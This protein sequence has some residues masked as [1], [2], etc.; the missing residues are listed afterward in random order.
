M[1]ESIAELAG[2]RD[3]FAWVRTAEGRAWLCD[4]PG[5]QLAFPWG[6]PKPAPGTF[7]L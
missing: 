5:T 7:G 6:E 1:T 4:R 3:M 2:I